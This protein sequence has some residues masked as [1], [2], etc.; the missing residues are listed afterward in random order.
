M[1]EE[2]KKVTVYDPNRTKSVPAEVI[3]GETAEQLLTAAVPALGLDE[4]AKHSLIGPD[5]V[6]LPANADVYKAVKDGGELMIGE[7]R[8]GA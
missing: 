5:K 3:P 2:I 6:A 1:A 8:K 7:E 4:S